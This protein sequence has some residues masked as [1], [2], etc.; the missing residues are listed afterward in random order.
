MASSSALS[1]AED[2][3]CL[4]AATDDPRLERDARLHLAESGAG[5]E[6]GVDGD[7]HGVEDVDGIEGE[8]GGL[9]SR[10]VAVSRTVSSSDVPDVTGSGPGASSRGMEGVLTTAAAAAARGWAWA[11]STLS[12]TVLPVLA[13]KVA[14]VFALVL[15]SSELQGLDPSSGYWRQQWKRHERA[16]VHHGGG[17]R[18]GLQ[19]CATT[20]VYHRRSRVREVRVDSGSEIVPARGQASALY[21]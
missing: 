18:D 12:N 9:D 21:R 3:S 2:V 11:A 5:V 20:L 6:E 19:G 10:V 17:G 16:V 8:E 4:R 7:D 14:E 1:P 13:A 15:S